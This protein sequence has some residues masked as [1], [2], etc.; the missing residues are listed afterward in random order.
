VKRIPLTEVP[1]KDLQEFFGRVP[2]EE[3]DIFKVNPA[4]PDILTEWQRRGLPKLMIARDD[5]G[6]I[7]GTY[8][9]APDQGWSSHVGKVLV[10]VDP[11][12]R[13]QGLG[14]ELTRQA[15]LVALDLGLRKL[16]AELLTSQQAAID[17]FTDL[18]FYPEALLRAHVRDRRGGFHDLVLLAHEVDE[19]RE[20]LGATGI[21]DAMGS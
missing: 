20:M 2:E 16:V 11:A 9:V 18:G 4:D 12:S 8:G 21:L 13:G 7:V 10:L 6:T 14:R 15:V 19:N 17:M 3:L 1:M 5:D